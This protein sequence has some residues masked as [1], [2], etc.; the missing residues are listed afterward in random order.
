VGTLAAGRLNAVDAALPG[1]VTALWITGSAAGGDYRPGR[2]DVDFVAATSRVPAP[3]DVAALGA[4][5][6][7][8]AAGYPA[9]PHW[10]GLYVPAAGL[11][12]PPSAEEPAPH[13]VDGVFGTGPCGLCTPVGWL[14]L[15]QDGVAVRGP[16]PAEVVA[17]PEPAVLTSWLLGN[18]RGYWT[19][20]ADAVEQALASR[21]EDQPANAYGVTWM[22]LGAARLLVTLT[23]GRVVTKTATG[24]YVAEHFPAY[25][26]LAERCVAW[27]AG[28][29]VQFSNADGYAAAALVRA[30]VTTAE[31]TA[32]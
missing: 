28:E 8:F 23:T 18:L 13:A 16:A 20:E 31:D 14:E 27:R 15:R 6:E 4:L 2:S 29:D 11:A 5:H 32:R 3:D 22:V 10:D 1:L 26:D 19:A 7:Q 17:A 21:P 24:R 12:D 25:A 9:E 30:V